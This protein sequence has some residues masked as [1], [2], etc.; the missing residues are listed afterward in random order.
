MTKTKS[1]VRR[2][3]V[4]IVVILVVLAL[5]VDILGANYL[6][7]FAI[8]R[9]T[10][11]GAAVAPPPV[12]TSETENI[13]AKNAKEIWEQAAAWYEATEKE[14]WTMKSYDGL[15][16][17]A[18]AFYPHPDSHKWAI[19]VHGYTSR[20]AHMVSYAAMFADHGFNVLTPDLKGHGDSEGDYI[21]MGWHDRLDLVAWIDRVLEKDPEA[22][23]V[24]HGVSMGGATVMMT[25]GEELPEQVKAIVEDCGY[26][27]VWDIF[28]DEM[29]ALFNLP[30]FPLLHT[31]SLLAKLRAGYTFQEA[32]ALK[33]VEKDKLPML[34]IH[35]SEDNFV[36]TDMVY[37]VYDACPA[38]KDLLV[39]EN[40]GHGQS[41][42]YAP[43]LYESRVFD[44][45]APY[46]GE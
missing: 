24:L 15:E 3:L 2:I 17:K 35:G 37:R 1:K 26:T 43:E 4:P 29:K 11:G 32:T 30:D 28:S 10:S 6:V 18:T 8:G 42:T 16:L 21:G 44:F 40:A 13:V 7:S 36:H 46:M 31:A 23:I 34:F 39:V 27:S 5:A 22:E 45:L 38:P 9:T 14:S 41:Y 12:T 19:S 25:S 20:S 33:Q